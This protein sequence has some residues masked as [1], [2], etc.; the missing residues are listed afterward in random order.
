[1]NLSKILFVVISIMLFFNIASYSKPI[2][3]KKIAIMRFDAEGIDS[4]SMKTAR[5]ILR[6]ETQRLTEAEVYLENFRPAEV[7]GMSEVDLAVETGKIK[8]A[9]QVVTCK[10]L[11]LGE[12][13]IIQYSVIDIRIKKVLLFDSINSLTLEE[14][15]VVMKRIATSI[16]ELQPVNKTAETGMIVESEGI[17]PVER[18][19]R[20]FY[21]FNFGYLFPVSEDITERSFTLDY[22]LGAELQENFEYGIN[23]FARNGFGANI[24]SSFLVSKKDV[25]PYI[26]LGL[27]FHWLNG[28]QRDNTPIYQNGIYNF[29]RD[30]RKEDGLE[31]VVNS[32]IKIFNTYKFRLTINATYSYTFNDFDTNTFVLTVGFL[33]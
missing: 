5:E 18:S 33:R 14:L 25:C 26:G 22:K 11:V 21:G 23:F 30:E 13:L 6:L 29:N 20:I 31:L 4:L 17:S 10:L 2:D 24:F 12:K 1:M 16:I 8:N 28:L 9:D 7:E 19:G 15:D 3:V 32:G 27:G